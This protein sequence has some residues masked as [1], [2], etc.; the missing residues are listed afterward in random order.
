MKIT[1]EYLKSKNAC[2]LGVKWFLTQTETDSLPLML[3]AVDS[4]HADYALWLMR[5]MITT[6]EQAVKIAI[7]SAEIVIEIFEKNAQAIT[8]RVKR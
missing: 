4:C 7:F 5:N 8:D 1:K 2:S 6:K 3:A